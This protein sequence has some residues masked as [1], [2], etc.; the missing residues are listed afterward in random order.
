MRHHVCWHVRMCVH[1]CINAVRRGEG[2]TPAPNQGSHLCSVRSDGELTRALRA[3]A[4]AV[5]VVSVEG[6]GVVEGR[7]VH[8]WVAVANTD[9]SASRPAVCLCDSANISAMN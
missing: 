5:Y 7:H 4:C 3:C 8:P 6:E 2:E 1:D 9:Q